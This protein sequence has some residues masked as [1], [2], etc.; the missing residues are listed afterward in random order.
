MFSATDTKK[1]SYVKVQICE[2]LAGTLEVL[3]LVGQ[4]ILIF[5]HIFANERSGNQMQCAPKIQPIREL[6]KG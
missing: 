6:R 4:N 1:Y 3:L 2:L 5:R